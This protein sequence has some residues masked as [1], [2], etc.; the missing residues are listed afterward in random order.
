[1]AKRIAPPRPQKTCK[2][3]TV[4]RPNDERVFTDVRQFSLEKGFLS[5]TDKH[6]DLHNF[7]VQAIV[8]W[9]VR[10]SDGSL[11]DV[12]R[13]FGREHKIQGIKRVRELTGWG[14]KEAKEFSDKVL[15]K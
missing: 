12:V 6:G 13:S 3:L 9:T 2:I 11:E 14:L 4:K 10:Q 8:E 1:M 15:G 7:N 5:I